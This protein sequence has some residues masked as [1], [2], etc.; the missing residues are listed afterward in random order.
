MRICL[1]ARSLTPVMCG[2]GRYTLN[3][4]KAIA[5]ID[6]DNEYIVLKHPDYKDTIVDRP[7]FREIPLAGASLP[8]K[9]IMT[10]G[11]V[12]NRFNPDV[13]HG[14]N[15]HIPFGLDCPR[16]LLT[17]HDLNWVYIVYTNWLETLYKR[18]VKG[19]FF[20]NAVRYAAKKADIVIAISRETQRRA[21]DLLEIP[22]SKFRLIYHGLDKRFQSGQMDKPPTSKL[23]KIISRVAGEQYIFSFGNS[24]LHKN[25]EG[26]IRAF[27]ILQ[28]KYPAL[29]LLIVGRGDR[30]PALRRLVEE[31]QLG[32]R[33]IFWYSVTDSKLTDAEIIWLYRHAKMLAFPS[34]I[35]GF[36]YPIV[37][38][39]AVGCPVLTSR[40]SAPQE[41]AAND[42]VLVDPYDVA[43]IATGMEKLLID[44]VLRKKLI[45]SGRRRA[46]SFTAE[47]CANATHE[48][49]QCPSRE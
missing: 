20:T 30:Y 21:I 18:H 44:K 39:M 33:I 6:S 17:L 49:Y 4:V 13:Y 27:N 32:D 46:A 28:T 34:F 8:V 16:T 10:S 29:M 11:S 2:I 41:I 35:E 14:L 9:S 25:I 3:L 47:Q 22:P 43:S 1:D 37:E 15:N 36:G 38:A 42:A 45:V 40:I 31:L 12:I 48:L 24:S 7:N 5:N 26:V 23:L 19:R